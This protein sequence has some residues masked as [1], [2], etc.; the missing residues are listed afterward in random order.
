MV[1]LGALVTDDDSTIRSRCKNHTEGGKV[2]ENI[3]TPKFL[4]DPGHRIK[5]MGKAIFKVMTKTKKQM[6]FVYN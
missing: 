6:K 1:V 3:P 2:S 5:V 4:T